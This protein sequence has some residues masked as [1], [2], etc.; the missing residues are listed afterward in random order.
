MDKPPSRMGAKPI[1]VNFPKREDTVVARKDEQTYGLNL[2]L[3]LVG[4]DL[5]G[6]PAPLPVRIKVVTEKDGEAA[7]KVRAAESARPSK[8]ELKY[9]DEGGLYSAE[10][11]LWSAISD[12]R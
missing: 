7:A 1:S 12:A 6:A 5:K 11:P 9:R 10:K 2:G 8:E 3:A 4:A